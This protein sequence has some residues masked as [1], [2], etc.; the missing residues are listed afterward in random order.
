M[1]RLRIIYAIFLMSLELFIYINNKKKKVR[2]SEKKGSSSLAQEF[3]LGRFMPVTINCGFNAV[4]TL[5]SITRYLI[6]QHFL[7]LKDMN[8]T[9]DAQQNRHKSKTIENIP[10]IQVLQIFSM[11]Y[12]PFTDK[13][14]WN[15]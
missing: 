5:R 15:T 4:L 6:F 1:S 11:C 13:N 14:F 2:L 9:I 12:I 7:A 8:L 3:F 10:G